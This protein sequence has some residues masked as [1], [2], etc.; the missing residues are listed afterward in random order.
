MNQK[1]IILIV[2][3]FVL[4]VAGMF[5]YAQL[6]KDELQQVEVIPTEEQEPVTDPYADITR[7]DAKH[8]LIDGVHTLVGEVSMPTPCDLLEA[9][10]VVAES[11]P[12][13]VTVEFSVINTAPTCAQ[14]ITPQRFKVDFSA[15]AEAAIRATFM[16]R[17]VELNLIPA[18]PGELPEDFEVFLKG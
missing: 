12:E 11:Y 17:D 18:G 13:Q 10:A 16:G 9:Q 2:S 3:L 14:V 1:S 15:S 4:I 7:I 5:I 8:Y 6:K